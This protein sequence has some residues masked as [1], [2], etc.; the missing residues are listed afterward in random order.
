M[1]AKVRVEEHRDIAVDGEPA[2]SQGQRELGLAH[3]RVRPE[4]QRLTLPR[5]PP[6]PVAARPGRRPRSPRRRSGKLGSPSRSK[7]ANAIGRAQP[8]DEREPPQVDALRSSRQRSHHPRVVARAAGER[9]CGSG[10]P[11]RDRDVRQRAAEMGAERVRLVDRR[12]ALLAHQVDDRLAQHR[13]RHAGEDSLAP[14]YGLTWS[15]SGT[16]GRHRCCFMATNWIRQRARPGPRRAARG[17]ARGCWS[18]TTR[19]ATSGARGAG[20]AVHAARAAARGALP[21]RSRAA[22]RPRPG[23]EP[24]TRQGARPLR[25]R[26]R[27][28]VLELCRPDDPR[29]AQAPLPRPRMVGARARATSR[30]GSRRSTARSPSCPASLA[31]RRR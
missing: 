13:Q 17:R 11:R 7:V 8:G 20:A 18:A 2:R 27:R 30:S 29:R 22:R 1:G 6:A 25:P 28:R 12:R 23:G 31:A 19:T 21:R 3:Q 10:A 15:Q 14:G 5:P 16:W 24:R 4:Y 9:N 26:A